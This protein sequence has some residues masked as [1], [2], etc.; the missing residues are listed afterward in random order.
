MAFREYSPDRPAFVY[1]TTNILNNKIYVG[2]HMLG[3]KDSYYLGS[4]L[5]LKAAIK[6]YGK[7]NFKREIIYNGSAEKCLELEEFIVDG[8]FC[9]RADTYNISNGG[10]IMHLNEE[11]RLKQADARRNAYHKL[12]DE[13]KEEIKAHL[14]SYR[15]SISKERW[16]EIYKKRDEK[17]RN[18]HEFVKNQQIH[19]ESIR[20]MAAESKSKGTW[21]TPVGS[22][23]NLYPAARANNIAASTLER[24]CLN[25]DKINKSNKNIFEKGKTFREIGFWFEAK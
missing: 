11:S 24:F 6:K 9:A 10:A 20:K 22:F 18:D 1:K 17:C 5:A 13:K 7:E 21:Y 16:E 4:G 19:L 2:F 3:S 8:E 14:E 25:P 15:N 23:K 12:P